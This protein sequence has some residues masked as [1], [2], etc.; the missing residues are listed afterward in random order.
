M[1]CLSIGNLRNFLNERKR[2]WRFAR[3]AWAVYTI[4]AQGFSQDLL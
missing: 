2:V 4:R 3:I 1:L